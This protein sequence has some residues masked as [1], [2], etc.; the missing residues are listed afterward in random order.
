LIG[1]T[2][3]SSKA[4]GATADRQFSILDDYRQFGEE[5]GR[6]LAVAAPDLHTRLDW[7]EKFTPATLDSDQIDAIKERLLAELNASRR[8]LENAR[9]REA[10]LLPAGAVRKNHLAQLNRS[11]G[12]HCIACGEAP[13]YRRRAALQP[14]TM[15]SN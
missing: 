10:E 15:P 14:Y 8:S 5:I 3:S 1:A 7:P 6:F 13:D 2:A 4:D 12:S 9:R 11:S